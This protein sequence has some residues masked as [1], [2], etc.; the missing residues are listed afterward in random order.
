MITSK[1]NGFTLVN[2][3]V[4]NGKHKTNVKLLDPNHIQSHKIDLY[5]SVSAHFWIVYINTASCEYK[6]LNIASFSVY[7][8]KSDFS[9]M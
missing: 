1:K 5:T 7:T 9:K 6:Q 3:G 4:K 8:F 2:T